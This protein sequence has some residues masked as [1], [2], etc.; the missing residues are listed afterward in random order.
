MVGQK[1][2]APQRR[3]ANQPKGNAAVSRG[4]PQAPSLAEANRITQTMGGVVEELRMRYGNLSLFLGLLSAGACASNRAYRAEPVNSVG[5]EHGATPPAAQ[6]VKD[7]PALA[8]A[9]LKPESSAASEPKAIAAAVVSG[10]D[11]KAETR[12]I[13]VVEEKYDKG[14]VRKRA[15]GYRNAE[16]EFVAHGLTSTWYESGLKWTEVTFKDG[17]KH[18]PQRKWYNTGTEWSTGY[19]DNGV[20]DGTWI[21]YHHNG[22]KARE[23]HIDHGVW[24]GPYIEYHKNG[25]KNMEVTFIKGIRQGVSTVWD[26]D[27]SVAFITDYIDGV[28]QP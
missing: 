25:R 15:E 14:V 21:A 8:T 18:G 17:I 24:D 27:G 5:Q 19:Y 23:F 22:E 6:P 4:T 12:Q 26:E 2:A 3:Y 11:D 20:E 10:N 1:F 13:E 16:G 9:P 28:E 7:P